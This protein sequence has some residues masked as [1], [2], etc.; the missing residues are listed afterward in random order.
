M[1]INIVSSL[2]SNI[3]RLLVLADNQLKYLKTPSLDAEVILSYVLGKPREY[4]LSHTEEPI[5]DEK[6]KE[7]TTLIKKR[8]RHVPVA[9]LVKNKEFYGRNFFIDE[10]V[11]IPRPA[12]ED[13]I[14]FIKEKIT[15]DFSGAIADIGAGSGCIAVTLALQY[16]QASIIATDISS[17]ALVVAASNAAKHQIE[18]RIIFGQGDLFA[19]L[20]KTMDIIVSNPPYGWFTSRSIGEGGP[21]IWSADP[22]VPHQPKESYDGG[23]DGLDVIKRLI[24]EAPKYLTDKKGQLFFE[25]DPRQRQDLEKLLADTRFFYQIKKDLAGFDRIALLMLS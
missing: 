17:D 7:F 2:M 23:K 22:E 20:P 24:A 13:L 10:R 16:P 5:S 6:A 12:T 15:P 1:I 11:H 4:I 18:D 8:A 14:D 3:K 9:Y 19:P 21:D 25:F